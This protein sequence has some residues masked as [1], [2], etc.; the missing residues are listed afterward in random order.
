MLVPVRVGADTRWVLLELQGVLDTRTGEPFAKQDLG[1]LTITKVACLP[2]RSAV[3]PA[4]LTARPRPPR[5][6]LSF[7]RGRAARRSRSVTIS[8]RERW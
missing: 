5:A 7:R 2:L 3:S 8:W 6:P 1:E 4:H